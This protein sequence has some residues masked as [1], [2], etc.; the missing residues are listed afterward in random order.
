MVVRA[1]ESGRTQYAPTIKT[2][3]IGGGT[4][5]YIDSNYIKEILGT[6]KKKFFI[7]KKVEITLEINPRYGR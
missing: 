4:P 7:D 3:Y 5:S 1:L 6:I 2:I